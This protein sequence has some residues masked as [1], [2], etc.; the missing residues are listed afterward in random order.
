MI[1]EEDNNFLSQENPIK[2]EDIVE[3]T[4]GVNEPSEIINKNDEVAGQV[5]NI[6]SEINNTKSRVQEIRTQIG[7]PQTVEIPSVNSYEE[8]IQNLESKLTPNDTEKQEKEKI[9]Q[10]FGSDTLKMLDHLS[11]DNVGLVTKDGYVYR[12]A[13]I[14]AIDDLNKSGIVR[15][16]YEAGVGRKR[17]YGKKVYWT[18]GGDGA[19]YKHTN[20]GILFE[21]QESKITQF[22]HVKKEDISAIYE[23]QEGQIIDVTSKYLS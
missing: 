14:M 5:E 15:N 12:L 20:G 22:E 6:D 13:G 18:R 7:L 2:K 17:H 1:S 3:Q 23:S 10:I 9:N 16:A 21:V 4:S 8:S 11:N 19:R